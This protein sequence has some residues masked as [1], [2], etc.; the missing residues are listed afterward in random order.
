MRLA[1]E[2]WIKAYITRLRAVHI[3]VYVVRHG[4]DTSGGVLVKVALLNGQT[5]IFEQ[6][7]DM[8]ADVRKWEC[9]FQGSD[10]EANE[11]S[12]RQAGRDPDLW[13]IEL[14]DREGRHL[15]DEM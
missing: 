3:P 11:W 12:E 4:E 8:L 5:H 14:E 2:F 9:V 6:R 1:T 13:V 10:Q 7:Y 15:L